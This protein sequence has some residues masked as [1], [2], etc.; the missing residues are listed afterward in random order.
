ML[1][2]KAKKQEALLNEYRSSEKGFLKMEAEYE[3]LKS[4]I[5]K[6]ESDFQKEKKKKEELQENIKKDRAEHDQLLSEHE[7]L[8][9]ALSVCAQTIKSSLQVSIVDSFG[10]A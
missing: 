1:T 10:F 6:L 5:S 3:M 4:S 2:E 7:K 9:A 8:S